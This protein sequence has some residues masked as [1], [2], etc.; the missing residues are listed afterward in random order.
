M[1]IRIRKLMS[2]GMKEFMEHYR[3]STEPVSFVLHS[4]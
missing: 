3:H 1:L 2:S 4:C